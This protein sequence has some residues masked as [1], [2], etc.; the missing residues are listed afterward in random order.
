MSV[1][2]RRSVLYIPATN[3]RAL[4]KGKS[5]P[6]DSIVFDLEDAVVPDQ[7]EAARDRLAGLFATG[8][9]GDRECVARVNGLETPWG[10][11]DLERLA[12]SGADAILVP[13]I[14]TAAEVARATA[15]LAT[16]DRPPALWIMVETTHAVLNLREI[17][18][19]A[20]LPGAR[21]A[22]FVMG[23]NDLV[24]ETR[25]TLD[26]ARTA[27]L[28][29]FS[30]A[31]TA[32]R[33]Y[34]IDVLDSVYNDFR[35]QEGFRRECAQGRMLGMDGKTVIHPAQID[36]ANTVYSPSAD[37]IAW[38]SKVMAHFA[39]PANLG[40][41]AIQIDGQMVERLHIDIAQRLL[42]RAGRPLGD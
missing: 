21:L 41:G 16:A 33:A 10:I 29:W 13:K 25:A 42:A 17:A 36:I 6:A 9:Y 2:P 37:E 15:I 34:G 38:A 1:R 26:P 8:C 24:K 23:T 39:D 40:K 7:K 3:D 4:E 5:L 27:G 11:G 32:A 20:A 22:C 35:D 18:A 31:I 14:R 19:L 30:A 28:Y 12:G